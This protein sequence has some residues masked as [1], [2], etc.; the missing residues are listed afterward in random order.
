[1][2]LISQNVYPIYHFTTKYFLYL[3]VFYL[4]V[5]F[6]LNLYFPFYYC[7]KKGSKIMIVNFS[8]LK[9]VISIILLVFKLEGI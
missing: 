3:L 1:M 6:F 2:I 8:N 7:F 4:L 9:N 5:L